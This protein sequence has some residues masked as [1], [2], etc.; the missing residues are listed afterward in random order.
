MGQQEIG[1]ILDDRV[2]RDA[3]RH[4]CQSRCIPDTRP[5]GRGD[6]VAP[7]REAR[8]PNIEAGL[9][10]KRGGK[11][12]R[13]DS[14]DRSCL[15]CGVLLHRVVEPGQPHVQ[16]LVAESAFSISDED[17]QRIDVGQDSNAEHRSA[18]LSR[19][20]RGTDQDQGQDEKRRGET[21]AIA[22]EQGGM[23]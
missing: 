10:C 2:G 15:E 3:N 13:N 23:S 6:A 8:H 12:V 14:I 20:A 17:G 1:G 16:P 21:G 7:V 18:A 11:K 22:Q 9:G 19:N 4:A 5:G